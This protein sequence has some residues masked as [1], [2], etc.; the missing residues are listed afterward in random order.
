MKT[1]LIMFEIECISMK[2]M[3][4]GGVGKFLWAQENIVQIWWKSFYH[5]CVFMNNSLPWIYHLKA[6]QTKKNNWWTIKKNLHRY[7]CTCPTYYIVDNSSPLFVCPY[8]GRRV[9]LYYSFFW[10]ICSFVETPNAFNETSQMMP[11]KMVWSFKPMVN[12]Q[13]PLMQ[14]TFDKKIEFICFFRML[15]GV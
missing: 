9:W 5:S 8:K 2:G 13:N 15:F 3:W 11:Q 14:L 7:T 1:Y 12:I 4:G 10:W 6:P